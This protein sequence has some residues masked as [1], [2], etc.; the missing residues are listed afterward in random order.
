M[1][2]GVLLALAGVYFV[3][4][5]IEAGWLSPAVRV[6][7]GLLAGLGAL[8]GSEV[9]RRRDYEDASNGLAG[10]GVVV[11][12]AAVWA[13]RSLYGLIPMALAF[14]L[15]VLVTAV[16]GLLAWRRASLVVALLGLIGGFATPLLVSAETTSPLGLF[17]YLLLLNTGLLVL[18]RK[19]RWPL[20]PPLG[21]LATLFYE[22]LWIVGDMTPR[23]LPLALGILTVFAALFVVA[24]LR[25]VPAVASTDGAGGNGEAGGILWAGTRAGAILLPF[26]F[27]LYFA[28]RADLGE[29]L[30]P[31]AAMLV[32][33]SIGAEALGRRWSRQEG[34]G[35]GQAEQGE[36]GWIGAAA[37][38][39]SVTIVAVWALDRQATAATAWELTGIA[40]AL[41][42]TFH[43]F[44]ELDL[45][46]VGRHGGK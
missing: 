7:L 18:G 23:E 28:L 12:Y 4:Y 11:L 43:A 37:A 36:L 38:V 26:A 32:V 31:V 19:R 21:L 2:A 1:L 17:G 15:M 8:V 41:A 46:Q 24:L 42:L 30:W 39:A 35:T 27:A 13:A 29:H 44:A 20:I 34:S 14:A 5:S 33:L 40:A 10:G 16:C 45:R 9:L 22:A 25:A 6:A 3:R